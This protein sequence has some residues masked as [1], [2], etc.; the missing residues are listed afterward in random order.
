[1]S[2]AAAPIALFMP[3]TAGDD[4]TGRHGVAPV[5]KAGE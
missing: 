4:L 5:P 1:M 3:I 2:L